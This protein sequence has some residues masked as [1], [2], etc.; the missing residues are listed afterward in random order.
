MNNLPRLLSIEDAADYVGVPIRVLRG[1]RERREV[2]VVRLG[3]R[4]W[5]RPEDLDAWVESQVE[6]AMRGPLAPTRPLPR[7]SA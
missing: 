5:F 4:I 2:P 1:A 6:P 3:K 7:R